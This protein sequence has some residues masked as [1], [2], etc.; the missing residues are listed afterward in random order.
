[1]LNKPIIRFLI[2][3]IANLL[4]LYIG[5]FLMNDGPRTDWYVS[6][7]KAPWTPPNWMFGAAWTTIMI[8]FSGYMTKLSFQHNFLNKK[9]TLLYAVQWILNVGWNFVFFNQR[10]TVLGLVVISILLLLIIY[11]T[12]NFKNEL[13]RYSLLILPYF[14]WMIIATS[15]NTYIVLNN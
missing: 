15:L 1:M 7:E 6:L 11:F 14:L 5:V 12:F 2:F 3:L 8:L 9:L 4:A 10:E 13:K